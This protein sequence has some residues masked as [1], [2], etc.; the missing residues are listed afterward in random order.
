MKTLLLN[1]I[2]GFYF[3]IFVHSQI[4]IGACSP[5]KNDSLLKANNYDF[6]EGGV[7]VLLVP[8]EH[9]SVYDKIF[10]KYKKMQLPIRSCTSFLPGNYK[11]TGPDTVHQQ[12]LIYSEIAFRRAQKMKIPYIVFGS[13]RAR[14]IPEG[15]DKKAATDQFISLL[16]KM[17]SI[18]AKYD[19]T[20]VIEPLNS[21]ETNF[22]NSVVEG[23]EIVKAVNHAN[24]Q[25]LADI[26]HMT[27]EQEQASSIIQYGK[28]IKHVHIAEN[29]QRTTPGVMGQDF[30]PYLKALKQINYKGGISIEAHV[31]DF[32]KEMS[33]AIIVL[34]E[35]LKD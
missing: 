1:I 25:L 18:A 11:V 33:K 16:K 15:F 5:I 7:S 28:Y 22:I 26:Y 35:Q 27:R 6:I 20:I 21:K 19:I 31:K 17:G 12:I 8:L 2:F 9:D 32:D 13:A 14:S 24:I 30:S 10:D 34:K 3:S 4:D 29:D 23:G